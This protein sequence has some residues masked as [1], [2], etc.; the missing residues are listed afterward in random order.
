MYKC[1]L[2]NMKWVCDSCYF[3]QRDWVKWILY[4]LLFCGCSVTDRGRSIWIRKTLTYIS[5]RKLIWDI[6]ILFLKE[7]FQLVMKY[8]LMLIV[9]LPDCYQFFVKYIYLPHIYLTIHTH[10]WHL[11]FRWYGVWMPLTYSQILTILENVQILYLQVL[12]FFIPFGAIRSSCSL[13]NNIN[14]FISVLNF[15]RKTL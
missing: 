8:A 6:K 15:A 7:R 14:I 1:Q 4:I 3:K 5:D 11:Y 2:M 10:F 13:G 9:N 12:F